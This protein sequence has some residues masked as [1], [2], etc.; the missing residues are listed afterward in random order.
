MEI[1]PS[2]DLQD[3]QEPLPSVYFSRS[4]SALRVYFKQRPAAPGSEGNCPAF[5]IATPPAFYYTKN[6]IAPE[7]NTII[8]SLPKNQKLLRLKHNGYIHQHHLVIATAKH[9]MIWLDQIISEHPHCASIQF[10]SWCSAWCT[11]SEPGGQDQDALLPGTVTTPAPEKR[12]IYSW[13]ALLYQRILPTFKL[14]VHCTARCDAVIPDL[15]PY[16]PKPA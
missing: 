15:A 6:N 2:R 14:C 7:D 11:G 9:I 5:H 12:G 10:F 8:A 4:M 13:A 1:I 3:F 16:S